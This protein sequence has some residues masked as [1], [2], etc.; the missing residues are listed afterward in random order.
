[1]AIVK[2]KKADLNI[3]YKRY[4]QI[5]MIIVL[6]L[7]IAAFKFSPNLKNAEMIKDDDPVIINILDIP[8]T[9]QNQKPLLPP[10]P[11]LPVI[12][13]ADNVIDIEVDPT[14]IDLKENM[15][16]PI[17]LEP[18]SNRIVEEE[19]SPFI[20]AEVMPELIGGLVNLQ[21]NV[22]YSE[23]ARRAEIE[24]KVIIEFIVGRNGDV[25]EA[26]VFKGVF[27][28]L[29]MIALNAVKQAKFTPALQRG[30]PVR[31]RMWMPIVF[32]LK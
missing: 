9:E 22:Y 30:K 19:D 12:T 31:V 10:K 14:D 20:A 15:P 29:D 13:T 6:A 11:T 32:K 28:E 5:S 21:K 24:G 25:E 17:K 1:M 26:S 3:H 16:A 4:F 27:E 7:L 23:L 8:W 2:T 18:P